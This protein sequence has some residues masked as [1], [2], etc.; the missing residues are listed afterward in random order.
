LKEFIGARLDIGESR[1]R[2]QSLGRMLRRKPSEHTARIIVLYIRN[3]KY[4]AI[5]EKADWEDIIG[6]ERNRYFYSL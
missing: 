4:E 1:E 5:Y 3:T 2:I 6:I